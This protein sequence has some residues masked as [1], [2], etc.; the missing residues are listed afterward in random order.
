MRDHPDGATRDA[1]NHLLGEIESNL[2]DTIGD[3]AV[4]HKLLAM[5][6]GFQLTTDPQEPVPS[7]DDFC[8]QLKDL[9]SVRRQAYKDAAAIAP[10]KRKARNRPK[11]PSH[12]GGPKTSARELA[13]EQ[14]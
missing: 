2:E 1:A 10:A 12:A 4:R 13:S 5:R 8:Q 7:F 3:E 6:H 11:R 14:V 9:P